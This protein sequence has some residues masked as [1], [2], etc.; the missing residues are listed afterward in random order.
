[1]SSQWSDV[2]QI[3]IVEGKISD[4]SQR[5]GFF[6]PSAHLTSPLDCK[7]IRERGQ[8][9]VNSSQMVVK[10]WSNSGQTK[11]FSPPILSERAPCPSLTPSLNSPSYRRPSGQVYTPVIIII[12]ITISLFTIMT[13]KC[14]GC[15]GL[16]ASAC[17]GP[18][19]WQRIMITIENNIIENRFVYDSLYNS[20]IARTDSIRSHNHHGHLYTDPAVRPG[21]NYKAFYHL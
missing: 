12:I 3:K 9:V 7:S 2:G 13:V 11:G 6:S 19:T 16:S 5:K 21:P 4:G 15:K 17:R 18:R 20:I 10:R 1:M 8:I 14:E